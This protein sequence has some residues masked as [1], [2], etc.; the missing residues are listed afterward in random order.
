MITKT[1][2]Q[3]KPKFIFLTT[4]TSVIFRAVAKICNHLNMVHLIISFPDDED[5]Q[6]DAPSKLPPSSNLVSGDKQLFQMLT[7]HTDFFNVIANKQ[8]FKFVNAG[9]KLT[10]LILI[11][12]SI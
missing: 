11:M 7:N 6:S 5:G 8:S 12:N 1:G 9:D 10:K 3:L 4:S 2:G